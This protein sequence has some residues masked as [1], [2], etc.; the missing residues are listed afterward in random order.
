MPASGT[1]KPDPHLWLPLWPVRARPWKWSYAPAATCLTPGD[2]VA[3]IKCAFP[4]DPSGQRVVDTYGP[5]IDQHAW[6]GQHPL[7]G[8]STLR[9][10]TASVPRDALGIAGRLVSTGTRSSCRLASFLARWHACRET[11][12]W[13]S[14]QRMAADTAETVAGGR[15]AASPPDSRCGRDAHL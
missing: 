9:G 5:R 13:M 14:L 8:R 3:N 1:A 6:R 15:P 7:S 2:L 4:V 10:V 12:G 11:G